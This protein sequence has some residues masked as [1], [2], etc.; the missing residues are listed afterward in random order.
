MGGNAPRRSPAGG[1]RF[2]G[3]DCNAPGARVFVCVQKVA[4][5][6]SGG[7]YLG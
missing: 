5:M 1:E 4:D 2:S 6:T 3:A 7:R